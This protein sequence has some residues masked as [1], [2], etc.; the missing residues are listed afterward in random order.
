[1]NNKEVKHNYS[2]QKRKNRCFA[3]LQ[4]LGDDKDSIICACIDSGLI[5]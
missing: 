5:E 2:I 1:M 3:V 4:S